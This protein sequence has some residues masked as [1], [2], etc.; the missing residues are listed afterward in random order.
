VNIL[1]SVQ[2]APG[3][4]LPPAGATS[5]EISYARD[6]RVT[7]PVRLELDSQLK[8]SVRL[9]N[10]SSTLLQ[11]SVLDADGSA[12]LSRTISADNNRSAVL[13]LWIADVARIKNGRR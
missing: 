12:L 2:P 3:A 4:D 10:A 13:T 5:V 7:R 9:E 8:G 11:A 6:D 1:F